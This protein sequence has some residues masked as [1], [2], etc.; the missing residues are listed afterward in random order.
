M[1]Y[2]EVLS[3]DPALNNG[4]VDP[5]FALEQQ[6]LSLANVEQ[7]LA[8]ARAR[9]AELVKLAA[10]ANA[11]AK[12]AEEARLAAEAAKS[13]VQSSSVSVPTVNSEAHS[14]KY[15]KQLEELNK[16]YEEVKNIAREGRKKGEVAKHSKPQIKRS[17]GFIFDIKFGIEDLKDSMEK[18]IDSQL[19]GE[20][21]DGD[22]LLYVKDKIEEMESIVDNEMEANEIASASRFGWGTVK[23]YENY[24]CFIGKEDADKKS[25]RF[26]Q[27]EGKARA[28]Y[29][30]KSF[31]G[32][33]KGRGKFHPYN[34]SVNNSNVNS[35]SNNFHKN[36]FYE[37]KRRVDPETVCFKC[38]LK[39]H[40]KADCPKN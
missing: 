2:R 10:E 17:I 7:E 25:Q 28:N 29:S 14:V 37:R 33:G 38:N 22:T 5:Q 24:S 1:S 16:K 32:F 9:E 20:V 6:Q 36:N 26:F 40:M 3:V 31:R 4:F 39:G 21:L 23:Y 35:S 18:L 13:T 19:R 30:N 11:N 8:A 34:N 27:A 12:K 15:I